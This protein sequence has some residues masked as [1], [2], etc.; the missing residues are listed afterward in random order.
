MTREE[1]VLFFAKK[2]VNNGNFKN[3]HGC[4]V[5]SYYANDPESEYSK[6]SDIL[7]EAFDATHFD[8][9]WIDF[10]KGLVRLT[11]YK[12]DSFGA[13]L[14]VKKIQEIEVTI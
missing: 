2:V 10:R 11:L 5:P 14:E 6:A 7:V 13:C 12:G 3:G 9:D 8:H 1:A 4:L